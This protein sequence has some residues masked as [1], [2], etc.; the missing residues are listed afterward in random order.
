MQP[1]PPIAELQVKPGIAR[2]RP[3]TAGSAA[4]SPFGWQLCRQKLP[5]LCAEVLVWNGKRCYVA[6]LSQGRWYSYDRG[7]VFANAG[8]ITH[9]HALPPPPRPPSA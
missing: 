5:P 9:W 2:T 3:A 1:D 7:D 8:C 4:A 6:W